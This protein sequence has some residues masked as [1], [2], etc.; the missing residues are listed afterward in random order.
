MSCNRNVYTPRIRLP[1]LV[2]VF[3]VMLSSLS[4]AQT[5]DA[6]PVYMDRRAEVVLPLR[7]NRTTEYPVFVVLPPT[8]LEASRVAQYL[9]LD[10]ERQEEFILIFPAGRPTR[11]EYLPDFLTFVEWY[12]ERVLSELDSVLENYSADPDRVYLGGYSLGGDLSWAL[13]VRNPERFAGAVIAGS[14]TSHPVEPEALEMLRTRG[15]RGSFLIGDREDPARY[16]GINRSRAAFA[17]AGI[18]HQY[19]EYSG[20]HVIPP[21]EIFQNEIAYVTQVTSLPDPTTPA[22]P[23]DA[24]RSALFSHT[25]RDRFALRFAL[26]AELNA[27]GFSR[28]TET[29][30]GLRGEWP[31][32]E[33]YLRSTAS[34]TNSS[35][36]TGS[37]ENILEQDLLVA[38]GTARHMLGVGFGWDWSRGFSGGD[39]L[40]QFDLLA[41]HGMRNPWIIPAGRN[42]PL[43]LDMLTL[44]RYRIPRG[45]G[46]NP[47]T[48]QLFNLELE[49]LLRIVDWV[50]LDAGAGSYTV[51]NRPVDALSQLSGALDHRLEWSVGAG[52]RAPSPLLWRVGYRG[53]GERALPDGDRSY[54]DLWTLTLEFSY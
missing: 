37:S 50:V 2:S 12:E 34:F 51:Q 16:D 1:V 18:E 32:E 9:G 41:A 11:D 22:V 7:Y 39:S 38:G 45:I 29:E 19:R 15:F 17:D 25:S 4:W 14:R 49:Y 27:D 5:T 48:A 21:P 46:E 47:A 35:R 13:S 30:I 6:K 10:P 52:L 33:F 42:D 31:W 26:P 43:R 40:H 3:L 44:L 8:G 53:I 20:A 36:T 23:S 54:R 24:A 28:P